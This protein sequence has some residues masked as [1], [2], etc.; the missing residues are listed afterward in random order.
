MGKPNRAARVKRDPTR[1]YYPEDLRKVRL[2]SRPFKAGIL[3]YSIRKEAY[4]VSTT[5]DEN[6]RKLY[7]FADV[8]LELK[9]EG[10][11]KTT[12][13]RHI[14]RQEIEAFLVW[15][16]K[17]NLQV[18]TRKSYIKIINVY[19]MFW[20][21]YTLDLMKKR[22]ELNSILKGQE[23]DIEYIEQVDL[24]RIFDVIRT[25][26]GYEGI[27]LRGYISLIFGIA[28][29]PK[30][31][32]D[33]YVKDVNTKDWL[34]Y[35][36]HPKGEGSWGK[37]EWMP[38]I[39]EDMHPIITE[40]LRQR[41][42]Y[43]MSRGVRSQFLF[44]NPETG[45]P[46]SLK[47]IRQLKYEV[48]DVSEVKFQLKAFRS[49]YATLTY[50]HSPDLGGAISKQ[51]RHSNEANSKKYYISYEKKQAAKHLQNEWRKSQIK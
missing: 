8:L 6:C 16:R 42:Q 38:I 2:G 35:I 37:T 28:G 49:T 1:N 24:Q 21:N 29:R 50:A 41:K 34:F 27:V 46:Y 14:G 48:E 43:L 4:N 9:Q 20:G 25:W 39:R 15:M 30:E 23:N 3:Y 22:H 7:Y 12:D 31:I 13:P 32:I 47:H 33:A 11:V 17:R 5:L 45:K 40:F 10:K 36:R 44:V 26:P 19:L 51:L 18:S